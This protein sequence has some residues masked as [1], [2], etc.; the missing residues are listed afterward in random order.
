MSFTPTPTPTPHLIIF[1]YFYFFT[2]YRYANIKDANDPSRIGKFIVEG[3]E[4]IRLL[5]E[6]DLKIHS[7]Y[8]KP[9]IYN[10][11]K[12]DIIKRYNKDDLLNI[13]RFAIYISKP[14]LMANVAGYLTARGS[15]ACG[16]RPV[17]RNEE[18]LYTNILKDKN[19]QWKESFRILAIDGCNNTANL[20]SL[21]RSGTAL[22]MNA[23]IIS[24]D[25]CDPWY[26]QCIRVS[27][28]HIFHTPIIKVN[29][30]TN[31]LIHLQS[32]CNMLT[33]GAVI[34]QNVHRLMQLKDITK[35][36][37]GIVG[38]EDKGISNDVRNACLRENG[39]YGGLCRIDMASNV[40]S[41]SI[42]VAAGI[43]LNGLCER[44]VK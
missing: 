35:R 26:R 43:F 9:T 22:G 32:E 39:Q 27:M 15:F 18:W 29:S 36:W 30:L 28:G 7:L 33:W 24:N 2:L 5:L 25:C 16:L 41:L 1:V 11:L 44:E 12:L 19:D 37:C 31:T 38:N 14:S 40:D 6:S 3:K 17:E 23:I 21:I 10:T 34:D 4:P 13:K 42:T 8:L 20:G